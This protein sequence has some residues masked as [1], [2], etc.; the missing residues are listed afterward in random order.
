MSQAVLVTGGTLQCSHGGTLRLQQGNAKLK[1]AGQKVVTA[2]ME[3][4]LSFAPGGPG[5]T[6]PCPFLSPS[7]AASPCTATSPATSGQAQKTRVGGLPAL[8]GNARGPAINANDPS[9]T[10]SVASAGQNVVTSS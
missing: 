3:A 6:V 8:L 9:A 5:V 4:G 2:T 7:S 10:W 1:A